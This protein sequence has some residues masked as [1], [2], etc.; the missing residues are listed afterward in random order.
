MAVPPVGG[1]VGADSMIAAAPQGF[2]RG[3]DERG[4]IAFGV[5]VEDGARYGAHAARA[6]G[7]V[8]EPD[9]MV[10]ESTTDGCVFEAYEEILEAA[11]GVPELE[12]L[13]LVRDDVELDDPGLPGT[14]RE[15]FA[16]PSVAVV[17]SAGASHVT[18]L[19]WWEGEPRRPGDEAH[20]VDDGVVALSA[21]AARGLR[22]AGSGWRGRHGEAAELCCL[23]RLNG[24]RV[25]V[26]DT[27]ARR[28]T[29]WPPPET[30]ALAAADHQWRL[31]WSA[32]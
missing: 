28:T 16:D 8:M 19:R 4:V 29:P 10:F 15:A 13:V 30:P 23:A 9:S 21:V 31:R 3:A 32:L 7:R 26:A 27:G 18:S 24:F 1:R 20:V 6:I 25:V 17:G 22:F 14:L 12:A 11:A 5:W 2:G